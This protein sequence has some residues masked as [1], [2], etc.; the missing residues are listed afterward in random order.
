M[1]VPK[2]AFDHHSFTVGMEEANADVDTAV[3]AGE[4]FYVYIAISLSHLRFLCRLFAVFC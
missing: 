4:S 2:H 1:S 3:A